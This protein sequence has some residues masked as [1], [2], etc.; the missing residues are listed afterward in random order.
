M[1]NQSNGINTAAVARTYFHWAQFG[2]TI[3]E[4]VSNTL[5]RCTV[6]NNFY[7]GGNFGNVDGNVTTNMTDCTVMGSAY[8]GGFSAAIP[9]FPVH[10]PSQVT[11]PYRDPAGVCHN[12]SV[13]YRTDGDEIRNYTWCYKNPTT[14]EVSPAGVVIPSS[15]STSKPA[16]QYDDKWYCYTTVSLENLGAVSGNTS[17]TVD[18]NSTIHGSVFGGGDESAVAGNTEVKVLGRTKVFGNVYGGGNMGE[19]GG[20]TKVII[21]G[22]QQP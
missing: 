5:D 12:G 15:V 3:T 4:T 14:N 22:Q 21:N 11:F 6:R 7:G 8:G 13:K 19:V 16:F 9:S 20:N 10:D 2:T 1:F 17:L 18:G